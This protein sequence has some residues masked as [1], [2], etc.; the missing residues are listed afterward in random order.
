M[1]RSLMSRCILAR[2]NSNHLGQEEHQALHQT[3]VRA[4][5]WEE[6][7]T[8]IG[9]VAGLCYG[10]LLLAKRRV[11]M[12]LLNHYTHGP[13]RS[14]NH[15]Y[16]SKATLSLLLVLGYVA[17][18][19]GGGGGA[20]AGKLGFGRLGEGIAALALSQDRSRLENIVESYRERSMTA[21]Q[22]QQLTQ[23]IK[24]PHWASTRQDKD[25][26]VW[27]ICAHRGF[28]QNR[29]AVAFLEKH[30]RGELGLNGYP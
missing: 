2:A 13:Q 10:A 26:A 30:A 23:A 8:W 12:P 5:K 9:G 16:T 14:V 21:E 25:F 7:G 24:I 22:V 11:I 18:L 29:V 28:L 19:T 15:V 3:L 17:A 20:A 1:R 4:R 27:V 6:R